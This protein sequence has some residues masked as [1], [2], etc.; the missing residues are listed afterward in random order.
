ME[1]GEAPCQGCA[2]RAKAGMPHPSAARPT[3]LRGKGAVG[4]GLR[5]R[6]WEWGV[7]LAGCGWGTK[8]LP[9]QFS[10]GSKEGVE[11]AGSGRRDGGIWVRYTILSIVIRCV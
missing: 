8:V 2:G 6:L 7:R 1:A 11:E 5:P 9:D 10:R 4:A 3:Y